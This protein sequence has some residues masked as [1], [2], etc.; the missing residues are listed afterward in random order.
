MLKYFFLFLPLVSFSQVIKG[1]VKNDSNEALFG[2]SVVIT[3]LS[4]KEI[5]AYDISDSEGNFSI[6]INSL[7]PKL[8]ISV[9]ILGYEEQFKL[10][11]H[12][13]KNINFILSPEITELKEVIVKVSKITRNKDTINYRVSSFANKKDRS[14]S[15]V[16]AKMPGIEVLPSGKILYQGKPISKYYI[17]G[18]DLL[19]GKY[20]LANENLPFNQVSKVQILENHQPIKILDSLVFTDRAAL[21]I[22]LK[23]NVSFTGQSDLGLG[24][25]P[26]LQENNITPMLFSKQGQV[27]G[28]YQ[29]NNT[30]NNIASQLETLIIED[31]NDSGKNNT[32]E[33]WVSTQKSALLAFLQENG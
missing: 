3:K 5:I 4:S 25:N 10:I 14:I 30:G 31:L 19:E 17:E 11:D 9:R 7:I 16:I 1:S 12:K 8:R 29:T 21:N 33:D 13:T 6:K 2:V 20:S 27:I 32:K 18:L 28:S 26:V 24:M 22:K 23:N 15:D